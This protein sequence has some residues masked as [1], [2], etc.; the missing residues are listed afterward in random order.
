MQRRNRVPV[1]ECHVL[2]R[3]EPRATLTLFGM[4][5]VPMGMYLSTNVELYFGVCNELVVGEDAHED[6]LA[7]DA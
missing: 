7:Y 5:G 6:A 1:L 3:L 4:G 2:S